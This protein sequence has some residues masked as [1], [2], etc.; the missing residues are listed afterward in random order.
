MLKPQWIMQIPQSVVSQENCHHSSMNANTDFLL[1]LIVSLWF[2]FWKNACS[3][4]KEANGCIKEYRCRSLKIPLNSL[5]KGKKRSTSKEDEV[6]SHHAQFMKYQAFNFLLFQISAG[7][8][9]D[10]K[11]L[12]FD[13]EKHFYNCFLFTCDQQIYFPCVLLNLSLHLV[14]ILSVLHMTVSV[15]SQPLFPILF[16]Q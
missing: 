12:L 6:V 5:Q 10:S 7:I 15:S 9:D 14:F 4:T 16:P 8:M 1:C 13:D 3:V 2:S 11:T